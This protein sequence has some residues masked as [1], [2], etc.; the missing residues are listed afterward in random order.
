MTDTD[1]EIADL[2]FKRDRAYREYL[3]CEGQIF[4][5]KQKPITPEEREASL[6]Q[7]KGIGKNVKDGRV[8]DG[9]VYNS[10]P[11]VKL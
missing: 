8:L 10:L 1:K 3:W 2:E 11:W 7:C 4:R 9:K 5:L 6:K